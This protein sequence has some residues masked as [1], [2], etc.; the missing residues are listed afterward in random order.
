MSLLTRKA[1]ALLGYLAVHANRPQPRQRLATL[2]WSNHGDR[3]ARHSLNQSLVAIRKLGQKSG[4]AVLGANGDYVWL[5]GENIDIDV[6]LFRSLLGQSSSEAVRMYQGPLLE[7]LECT[8]PNFEEWLLPTRAELHEQACMALENSAK[9]AAGRGRMSAAVELARK[10]ISFDPLR[11]EGHRLLMRL[12]WDSGDRTGAVRQY[13]TCVELLEQELQIEP[14]EATRGLFGEI[15]QDTRPD[16]GGGRRFKNP[17]V[18]L[19]AYHPSIAVLPFKIFGPDV[20]SGWLADGLT[21]DLIIALSKIRNLSV[22]PRQA[23]KANLGDEVDYPHVAKLLGVRNVLTGS[24]RRGTDRLRCAVQ[25]V[26]TSK[27]RHIWAERYDRPID[28]VFAVSDDIVRQILIELQVRLTAGESARVASRGTDNLEAWLLLVQGHAEG[29]KFTREGVIRARELIGA[30]QQIDPNWSAPYALLAWTH[31]LEAQRDWSPS[32]DES[33]RVGMELADR[34]ISI[35]P[36]YPWGYRTLN[37]FLFLRGEYEKGIELAERA[38]EIAPQDSLTLASLAYKLFLV[39]EIDRALETFERARRICPF[40]P[41]YQLRRYGLL[42]QLA[43]QVGRAIE[44]LEGLVRSAPDFLY[45]HAQLAAAY[46]HA[47]RLDAARSCARTVLAQDPG[48]TVS[49]YLK[50]LPFRNE[51]RL[52]WLRGLL[53]DA[54]LPA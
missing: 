47:K 24:V 7:G 2:L 48:F 19:D 34:A 32:R 38:A 14:D 1:R 37:G 4:A 17:N 8:E 53:L 44:V 41:E 30:A 5:A 45:G 40:L 11:E 23:V 15:A 33:I 12:L 3:Q 26:D 18:S 46:A 21:E 54:G 13:K 36:E 39:D 29:N 28:D 52:T 31:L 20:E 6:V 9:D 42:L 16:K 25:L 22:V 35:D 27:G 49:L 43:G 10:L 50:T 51:S